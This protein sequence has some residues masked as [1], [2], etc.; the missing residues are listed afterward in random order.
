MI[1]YKINNKI[2]RLNLFTSINKN[3]AY[4]L[5]YLLG[6]GGYCDFT[7]K[8]LARM[9]VSSS[10]KYII[11]GFKTQF[12]PDTTI[13]SK[14]PINKTRNIKSILESHILV[15]S[16]KFSEIFN[17]YGIL[18]LKK[19]RTFHNIPK[20]LFPSFLLGLFDADGNFSWGV[21][22]DRL[23]PWC[24]FKITH[25]NLN[26]LKKLQTYLISNY[27]ISTFINIKHNEDCYILQI[28][29]IKDANKLM[30]IIY[31]KN[32]LIYNKRKHESFL[33]WKSCFK[34]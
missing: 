21:R 2:Y 10:E 1:E 17:K 6:D 12:C 19:T 20:K 34:K 14:I 5:G 13:N 33:R 28:S 3:E 31:S 24:Q 22:R 18:S 26:M 11:E 29:S 16:S 30:N 9:F 32:N 4:L 23:R 15:F 7:H 8:R 27:N 25:Q